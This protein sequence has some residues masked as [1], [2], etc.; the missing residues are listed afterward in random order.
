MNELIH[1]HLFNWYNYFSHLYGNEYKYYI[2][3]T[4]LNEIHT[5]V[6]QHRQKL[7]SHQELITLH[8]LT[9]NIHLHLISSIVLYHL[10]ETSTIK[11]ENE[12]IEKYRSD[13][14]NMNYIIRNCVY[15]MNYITSEYN[16]VYTDYW[17]NETAIIKYVDKFYNLE[18]NALNKFTN[19]KNTDDLLQGYDSMTQMAYCGLM[20]SNYIT[21]MCEDCLEEY[22]Y[23]EYEYEDEYEEHGY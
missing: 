23:E 15:I 11:T 22:D 21:F 19:A 17:R 14:N 2:F 9:Q 6:I 5:T 18:K 8:N 13:I 3:N 1:N 16:Y 4:G 10:D 7:K 20:I 12:T